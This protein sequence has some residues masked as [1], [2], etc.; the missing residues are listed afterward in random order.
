[1]LEP[2]GELICS[3]VDS[4]AGVATVEVT[5]ANYHEYVLVAASAL[6]THAAGSTVTWY[7]V[8]GQARS[9]VL[10]STAAV[11]ANTISDLNLGTICGGIP[12]RIAWGAKIQ[13]TAA[14]VA[15]GE[16]CYMRVAYYRRIGV[17]G[18]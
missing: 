17:H 15:A 3:D 9:I 6:H 13:C 5:A 1:M 12:I 7:L 18:S 8:D 11:A 16:H 10:K 2:V 14:D 4:G